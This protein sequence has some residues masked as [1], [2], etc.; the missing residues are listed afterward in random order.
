M[1]QQLPGNPKPLQGEIVEDEPARPPT[2]AA[3]LDLISFIMDRMFQIPGTRTRAGLNAILLFIP[4]LGDIIPA[5]V[6]AGIVV[7]G[8]T[9]YRVP[10][11][12]AARMV[13]N[14]LLDI[15]LGWIPVA[16]DLFDLFFKADTR[17]VRLLQQYG[18]WSQEPPPSTWRH[19]LV[20]L[21]MLGLV[22]LI[23]VLLVLG[24]LALVQWLIR[25]IHGQG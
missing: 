8:L 10:R 16:G 25:G 11:I 15:T 24:G 3:V 21:G 22:G 19:W 12:V 9:N 7:V 14:S 6:S 13:L 18:G 5:L 4:I 1:T 2:Q 17:N 23:L 20:V